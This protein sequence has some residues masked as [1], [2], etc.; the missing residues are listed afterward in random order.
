MVNL[1]V[2]AYFLL[3]FSRRGI[4]FGPYRIDLDV[5]RIGARVW[6]DGGNLYGPLPPTA[7]G[8]GLPFTYP[9]IA[10]VA[11]APL[12]LLPMTAAGT[13]LSLVSAGLTAVVLRVFLRA[14][15]PSARLGWQTQGWRTQGWQTQGWRTLGWLLPVALVLEPVRSTIGFGQVNVLLMALVSVDCL[16][17]RARWPRGALVGVAAAMKL[18]PGAFILF[19]LVRRDYRAARTAALSF[20]V[21]TAVGFA[22]AWHDSVRYWTSVVFQ[23]GRPGSPHYAGNQSI[24]AV[25]VR[26]GLAPHSLAGLCV[27]LGA[28]AVVVLLACLGMRH[29]VD[30]GRSDWDAW[31]LSLNAFAALLISPISWSH[32]W[33]WGETAMLVLACLSLRAPRPT[34]RRYGLALATAGAVIF[35]AAPQWGLPFGQDR[36]L[37][38][39]IWQQLAGSSY[40]ILA[41]VAL[42][43]STSGYVAGRRARAAGADGLGPHGLAGD[44]LA[45][46]PLVSVGRAPVELAP[47]ELA[48]IELAAD[49]LAR[50]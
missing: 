31:A 47:I 20:C 16:D 48:P 17:S 18:T 15:W 12:S 37:H 22:L 34:M 2:L 39:A 45:P 19:F 5:Y 21:C 26:A 3:S 1:G 28:A 27:W 40:V 25:I 4:G 10:A 29:A 36:E 49:R 32:H 38:W 44:G 43:G 9:P 41:V 30:R 42:L 24:E 14:A 50:S 33:V 11:F 6:L 7:S 46:H 8:I 13:L 23:T 35:A